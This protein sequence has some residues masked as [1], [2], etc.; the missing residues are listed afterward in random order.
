MNQLTQEQI[1]T[2]IGEK[3]SNQ[4]HNI[5]N[6]N[7]SIPCGLCGRPLRDT[8]LPT[9]EIEKEWMKCQR[10]HGK[11]EHAQK[12][13]GDRVYWI[14]IC[15]KCNGKG[16]IQKHQVG[17]EIEVALGMPRIK[18]DVIQASDLKDEIRQEH[19][20]PEAGIVIKRTTQIPELI[21][22]KIISET[23][24]HWRLQRCQ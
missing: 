5:R 13:S 18:V 4:Y 20:L 21:K 6:S 17:E 10:C 23:E 3:C 16:K 12:D 2:V 15:K 19:N 1:K 7:D 24:T 9:I 11:G 14:R 22:L 8:G